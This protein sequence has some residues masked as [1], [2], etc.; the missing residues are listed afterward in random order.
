MK[1]KF[2]LKSSK[3][4]AEELFS[5]EGSPK[6]TQ[7]NIS[8]P[9]KM[10]TSS[11]RRRELQEEAPS[12]FDN[13]EDSTKSKDVSESDPII[14]KIDIKKCE[15]VYDYLSNESDEN[16]KVTNDEKAAQDDENP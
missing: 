2:A 13:E 3:E 1:K 14:N 8:S 4:L 7:E 15:E 5:P 6:Q 16:D 12:I 9:T 11:Q 10:M